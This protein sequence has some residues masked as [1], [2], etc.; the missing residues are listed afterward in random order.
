MALALAADLVVP[1]LGVLAIC[2]IVFTIVST[3]WH[4]AFDRN[5]PVVFSVVDGG[6]YFFVLVMAW[7]YCGKELIGLRECADAPRHLVAVA[8]ILS[9]YAR[10]KKSAWVR[11]ERGKESP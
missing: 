1:P 11:A 2:C 10:G 6:L 5:M 8:R 3:I 7:K 9:S 4:V